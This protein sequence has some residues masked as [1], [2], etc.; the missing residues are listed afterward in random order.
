[1]VQKYGRKLYN[2]SAAIA[3]GA[4]VLAGTATYANASNWYDV[5]ISLDPVTAI[6]A[7]VMVAGAGIWGMRKG[8]NALFK[9]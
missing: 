2:G 5:T 8:Y 4:L 1:M 7:G 6:M 9:S 3:G